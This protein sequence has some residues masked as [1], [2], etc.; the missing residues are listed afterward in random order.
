MTGN[1][2]D[3]RS[4]I[5]AFGCVVYEMVTGKRSAELRQLGVGAISHRRSLAGYT[6][7][8]LSYVRAVAS[9]VAILA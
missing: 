2:A 9:S 7:G 3:A 8:F 5:F 4:D 6:E 1:E